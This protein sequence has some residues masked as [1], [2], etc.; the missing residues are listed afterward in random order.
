MT[1]R[2]FALLT[3]AFLS[4]TPVWGQ[5]GTA[6]IVAN[7]D[8]TELRNARGSGAM[9]QLERILG[10]AAFDVD[11]A[12]NLS[13]NAMRAALSTLSASLRDDGHERVV[14]LFSGYTV[15]AGGTVWLMGTDSRAP[16]MA[17][18]EG[19]GVRLDTVLSIAGQIQGGAI[20]ALADYG[21]PDDLGGGFRG[22]LPPMIEVPQGVTLVRGSSVGVAAVLRDVSAPGTT[23][24][25]AAAGRS[26]VTLDG[27]N[28]PYLAFLPDGTSPAPAPAPDRSQEDRVAW[29]TAR[30]LDTVEGY[31]AYLSAYPQGD[32]V[33]EARAARQQLMNT[34]ERIEAAL[35]L[36]RDERRAIQRDLT[37]LNFDPRGIDGIFGSGTRGAIR[38]WQGRNDIAVTGY[39]DRDQIFRLAQQ[40]AR[41]AAELEEEA[42]ARAAEQERQDRQF[43]R[44]TGSGQDEVGMRAYLERFPDGIFAPVAQVRLAQIE[45]QRREAAQA[46]DRAAW[47]Q[48]AQ[49]DTIAAYQAYLQANPDG[50]FAEQAQGR[51][52]ELRRPAPPEVDYAAAQAEEDLMRLP[53]FTR[54][55][56][57]QRLERL[58]LEPG[59]ADGVFDDDT[60]RAIRRYQRRADLPVT[61]FLTQPIVA[62]LLAEGVVDIL[63]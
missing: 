12:T 60:R 30:D 39:L 55:I 3:A 29:Q 34:P 33:A 46:R 31:D 49:A 9:V 7:E 40:G 19:Y 23:V 28:P 59:P 13:A 10:G 42:R 2:I 15:S 17:S 48:A 58:G 16:D 63:R 61:G 37:I 6:L 14:I 18:V 51:I 20:V 45:A 50:A 41:R 35:G 52:E 53:T 27:F 26:D 44:D 8:Y 56:V 47:D 43:W 4:A 62:R 5:S 54:V 38:S 25:D 21:F 32:F 36:S 1:T 57:E 24:G 22:G 11:I